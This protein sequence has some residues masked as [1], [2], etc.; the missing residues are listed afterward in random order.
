MT[1]NKSNK[2]ILLVLTF[3]FSLVIGVSSVKADSTAEQIPGDYTANVTYKNADNPDENSM[4]EDGGLWD[5]NVKYTVRPDGSSDLTIKQDKMMSYMSSVTYLG[6]NEQATAI[7]LKQN[8]T[9]KETGSWKGHIDAARTAELKQGN[10]IFLEMKY[11]VPGLFSHDVKVL[12]QINSVQEPDRAAYEKNQQLKK[13]NQDLQ[14]QITQLSQEIKQD[15]KLN[16]LQNRV[17]SLAMENSKLTTDLSN[18]KTQNSSLKPRVDDLQVQTNNLSKSLNEIKSKENK[19]PTGNQ[20]KPGKST[21]KPTTYTIYTATVDYTK[22]DS[23]E[24]SVLNS[25][26]GKEITYVKDNKGKVTVKIPQGQDQLMYLMNSV[27][28]DGQKMTKGDNK[29]TLKYNGSLDDLSAGKSIK[30]NVNYNLNGNVSSHDAVANIKAVSDGKKVTGTDPD[31]QPNQ[32]N[33]S[34]PKPDPKPSKDD[35]KKDQEEQPRKTSREQVGKSVK[36]L[37]DAGIY[38]ANVSYHQTGTNNSDTGQPSMIQSD[39]LWDRN[40]KLVKNND[41][42]VTVTIQQPKW[43]GYMSALSF[44]GVKMQEHKQGKDSG[45]WT[46]TLPAAKA[47][48]LRVGNKILASMQYTVPGM[49][50]H[51]VTALVV[52]NS[53]TTGETSGNSTPNAGKGSTASGSESDQVASTAVGYDEGQG[54]PVDGMPVSADP[55]LGDASLPQT[56]EKEHKNNNALIVGVSM[57]VVIIGGVTGFDIYRRKQNA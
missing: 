56:G 51:D 22:P 41:G 11:T 35:P 38:T 24:S 36:S 10:K 37:T 16:Q 39:G 26:F 5:K 27:T 14:G 12:M 43:M 7:G 29:W 3:L 25:F 32:G 28:F 6:Q 48:D 45:Y 30:V 15:P 20:P 18:A 46:A 4:I 52:I 40:I 19:Q 17:N 54:V 34:Q 49:F 33:Q 21:P 8:K 57:F 2:Q 1:Q 31:N 23:N 13:Q 44:D 55:V 42:T 47:K 50:T 9:G 53:I